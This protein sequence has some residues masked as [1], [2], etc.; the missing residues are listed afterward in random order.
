M[1]FGMQAGA[2]TS[3]EDIAAIEGFDVVCTQVAGAGTPTPGT[4][5]GHSTPI[6]AVMCSG[7]GFPADMRSDM[8]PNKKGSSIVAVACYKTCANRIVS[9][10][11]YR[12]CVCEMQVIDGGQR[13]KLH[14]KPVCRLLL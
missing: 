1:G 12:L 14:V 7:K 11:A 3:F 2:F 4:H 8:D 13:G 9:A 10:C 5:P 6:A